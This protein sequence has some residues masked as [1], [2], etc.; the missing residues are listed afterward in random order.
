M[1]YVINVSVVSSY[2]SFSEF[3]CVFVQYIFSLNQQIFFFKIY[4][5][6]VCVCIYI[7]IYIYIFMRCLKIIT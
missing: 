1:Y 5:T 3:V 4:Y 7:Y 6:C 2:M